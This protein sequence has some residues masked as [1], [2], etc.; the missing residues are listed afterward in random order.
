M[1]TVDSPKYHNVW[2]FAKAQL[3]FKNIRLQRMYETFLSKGWIMMSGFCCCF[4]FWR[5]KSETRTEFMGHPTRKLLHTTISR[6][7]NYKTW[8]LPYWEDFFYNPLYHQLSALWLNTSYNERMYEPFFCIL[9]A[10][11]I[12]ASLS[13]IIRVECTNFCHQTHSTCFW[14]LPGFSLVCPKLLGASTKR[15]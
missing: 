6:I 4:V 2:K 7:K 15:A 3:D 5:W 14:K 9:E 12:F 1:T 10:T 8:K 13:W 11:G